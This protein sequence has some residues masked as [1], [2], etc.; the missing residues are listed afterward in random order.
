MLTWRLLLPTPALLIRPARAA[1]LP[2]GALRGATTAA[3][4]HLTPQAMALVGSRVTIP[5]FVAP[6]LKPEPDF[7]L[8]AYA[9]GDVHELPQRHRLAGRNC[10]RAPCL[11]PVRW[12]R[13]AR[14]Q[15]PARSGGV[16]PSTRS[17]LCQPCHPDR[18]RVDR[19]SS[20]PAKRRWWPR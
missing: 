12:N 3:G 14:P 4:V 9:H 11:R 18:H 19:Y 20:R 8:R 5:G 7:F 15:P 17:R 16:Q 13:A 1:T 6:P 2:F 10:V